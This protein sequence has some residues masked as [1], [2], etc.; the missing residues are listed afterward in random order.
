[1]IYNDGINSYD[2]PGERSGYI[3]SLLYVSICHCNSLF[4]TDHPGAPTLYL[5]I[6]DAQDNQ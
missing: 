2:V 1:M 5:R 6:L 4:R 3:M